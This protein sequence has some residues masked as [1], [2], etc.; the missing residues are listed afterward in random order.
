MWPVDRILFYF[1]NDYK[2][3]CLHISFFFLCLFVCLFICLFVYLFVCLFVDVVGQ[4]LT[5][6]IMSLARRVS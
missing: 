3:F 1:R 6:E 2:L 4:R 5:Q